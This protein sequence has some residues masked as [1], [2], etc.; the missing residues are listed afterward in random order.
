MCR[1]FPCTATNIK[2]SHEA[3]ARLGRLRHIQTSKVKEQV[4]K[5][6]MP[7]IRGMAGGCEP[8]YNVD[9]DEDDEDEAAS[10]P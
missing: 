2:A 7:P 1:R 9:G 6:L 10:V 4:E 3:H 5:R 8:T